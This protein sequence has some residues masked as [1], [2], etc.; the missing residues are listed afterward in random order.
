MSNAYWLVND[1]I[2][3]FEGDGIYAVFI[4]L[5]IITEADVLQ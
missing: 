5:Y 4:L 1:P 2:G 3:K